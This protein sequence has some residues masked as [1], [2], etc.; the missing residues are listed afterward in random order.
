MNIQDYSDDELIQ[1]MNL[2]DPSDRELEARIISLIE[3]YKNN[4]TEMAT[5][6]DQVY[7]RFFGNTNDEERGISDND[8]EEDNE[9][10]KDE[11][12]EEEGFETLVTEDTINNEG[13]II[14]SSDIKS[15][16]EEPKKIKIV[17]NI[18]MENSQ[19]RNHR[20]KT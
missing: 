12:D 6:F 18:K 17:K 8:D 9:D 15:Y 20:G 11:E 16:N 4:N 1:T 13:K 19:T 5:F 14:R 2:N 10:D 7:D 3:K